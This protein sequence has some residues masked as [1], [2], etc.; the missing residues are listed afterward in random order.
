M[1]K[2]SDRNGTAEPTAVGTP[3]QS[4]IAKWKRQGDQRG[5]IRF[6]DNNTGN[7]AVSNLEYVQLN[8]AMD[9]VHEWVVDWDIELTK[10]EIMLVRTAEWRAG[11]KFSLRPAGTE[12]A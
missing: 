12:S 9:H 2:K 7:C 6:L 4:I 3:T 8:D 1:T 5:F 10:E 11:L